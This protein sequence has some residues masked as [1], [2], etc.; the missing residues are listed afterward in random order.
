MK[1]P[2]ETLESLMRRH[3]H[4]TN[5]GPTPGRDPDTTYH[6]IITGFVLNKGDLTINIQGA[7][8]TETG[9]IGVEKVEFRCT[10]ADTQL[11]FRQLPDRIVLMNTP[12]V[13]FVFETEGA[14]ASF[15]QEQNTPT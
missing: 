2:I 12:F 14:F 13:L 9:S 8:Q 6:G 15:L 11:I 4:F 10:N 3:C 5:I 7:R 1:I